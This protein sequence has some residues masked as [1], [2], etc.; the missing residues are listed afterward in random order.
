M[1]SDGGKLYIEIIAFDEIYNFVIHFFH[2]K[3][4]QTLIIDDYPDLDTKT[5]I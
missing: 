1:K 3:S 4:S 5:E 2:L